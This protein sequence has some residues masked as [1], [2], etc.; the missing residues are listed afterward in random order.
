MDRREFLFFGAA[1]TTAALLPVVPLDASVRAANAER[2]PKPLEPV[3]DGDIK[4][5]HLFITIHQ[6]EIVPGFRFHTLAFN[7]QIP[8]P[9]IRVQRG[10]KVRVIFENR[11][12]INHTIHW[13]GLHVPWRMDGVP[14]VT[15]MP[16]MPG[17]TFVYEF[18]AEPYGTHF[19]HCHWGTLLH[20]QAGIYGSFIV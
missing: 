5:F 6:Q 11:T 9:E 10:D 20:M 3:M 2:F 16:V 7:R 19:Y 1:A 13:H 4:T 18:T 14:Y 12:E 8:G 17:R 15:Q